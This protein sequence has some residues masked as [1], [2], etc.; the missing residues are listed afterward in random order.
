MMTEQHGQARSLSGRRSDRILWPVPI[1]VTAT[2]HQSVP[3]VEEAVTVSINMHG[4]CISLTHTLL[5]GAIILIKN[6]TNGIEE[7]F[8]V[9]RGGEHVFGDRREW[10]VEATH[11]DGKI[12]GIEFNQPAEEVQ[13]KVLI[14]CGS[15]N[16]VAYR[17][18]TST[19]Y[20]L[21]LSLGMISHYCS[22]CGQTTRWKPKAQAPAD[23]GSMPKANQAPS[24]ATTRKVRR[25]ELTMRVYV[26][27]SSGVVDAVQTLDVSKGG[28][29]FISSRDFKI[30]D[31]VFIAFPFADNKK[32]SETKGKVLWSAKTPLG[33]THGV[34]YVETA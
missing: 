16:N 1:R 9:V 7:G 22:P 20:G 8:R 12:W 18:L 25:L 10:R 6:Q 31:S 24:G 28:L 34:N 2:D 11:P 4:A 33:R 13:P 27:D 26:R 30:G 21:L 3:F 5:P 17:A 19:E 23:D 32:T 14:E 15:C 29:A